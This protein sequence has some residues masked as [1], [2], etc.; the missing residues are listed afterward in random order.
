MIPLARLSAHFGA[1][2]RGQSARP[3]ASPAARHQV[4]RAPVMVG[5]TA[6][7]A[8]AL[9]LLSLVRLWFWRSR[10][11]RELGALDAD[12]LRDVG[13]SA[14]IARRESAKPFWRA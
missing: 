14:R 8:P 7:A 3:G 11:R 2:R 5:T 1:A 10:V 13:I 9:S 4:G 12:R 6:P